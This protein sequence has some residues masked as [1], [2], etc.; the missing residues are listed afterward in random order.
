MY[1]PLGGAKRKLINVWVVFTFVAIWHD[2]EWYCYIL[3]SLLVVA[4]I[5]LSFSLP[6]MLRATF[7]FR[8]LLSWAWLTCAFF[9]PEILVKYA[10]NTF[11]VR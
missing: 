4:V 7:G 9:L 10:A 1:I 8:K 3:S 5:M 11:Q 6:H 2:L